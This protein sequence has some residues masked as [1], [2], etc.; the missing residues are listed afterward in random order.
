[1]KIVAIHGHATTLLDEYGSLLKGLSDSGHRVHALVPFEGDEMAAR[2]EALGAEHATFPLTRHGFTPGADIGTLLHLKQVLFRIRP[3]LVLATT[4]KALLYGAMAA[5]MAWVGE[6]KQVYGLV[7]RVSRDFSRGSGLKRRFLFQIAKAM[8][9]SGFRS[10]DGLLF[11]D[12]GDESFF[13][14]LGVIPDHVRTDVLDPA[15]DRDTAI[16]SFIGLT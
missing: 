8:H 7:D 11:R 16:R 12:A 2:F 10:C 3:D 9:R 6:K 14:R 13:R 1:M 15:Q 5:R 4:S